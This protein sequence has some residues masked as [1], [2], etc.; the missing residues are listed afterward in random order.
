MTPPDETIIEFVT[1]YWITSTIE[2]CLYPYREVSRS[3]GRRPSSNQYDQ[4]FPEGAATLVSFLSPPS[5][6]GTSSQQ[7]SGGQSLEDK[8]PLG[9]SSFPKELVLTPESWV[10]ASENLVWFR[11]HDKVGHLYSCSGGTGF[12]WLIASGVL[13]VLHQTLLTC[14]VFA[15]RREGTLQPW[16]SRRCCYRILKILSARY[17]NRLA[18]G[19][20]QRDMN[21][22]R[23][24]SRK[25]APHRAARPLVILPSQCLV[26]STVSCL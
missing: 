20:T 21:E 1:L 8:T 2:R 16:N 9:Y 3:D 24:I 13:A 5:A 22:K 26:L 25:S 18:E 6:G 7:P 23:D 11:K 4:D 17:G 15:I 14:S 19:N 12:R 10:R